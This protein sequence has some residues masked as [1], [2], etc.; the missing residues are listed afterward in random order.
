M[1]MDTHTARELL[2]LVDMEK[3]LVDRKIFSDQAIY[4]LELEQIFARAWNFMGHVCQFPAPGDFFMTFI[5]EDRVICQGQRWRLPGPR[6]LLPASGQ[7]R[8]P[9]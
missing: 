7:R 3:G 8:L 2:A 6:Q 9:R 1:A 4:E 5:G